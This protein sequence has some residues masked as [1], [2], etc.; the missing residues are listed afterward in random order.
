MVG[1]TDWRQATERS[2]RLLSRKKD[3]GWRFCMDYRMLNQQTVKDVFPLP[4][5]NVF[6]ETVG[7]AIML[8]KMDCW[9]G[10]HQI[11]IKRRGQTQDII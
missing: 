10:F 3:G 7:H 6:I 5:A 2:P 8:S 11:L 4:N 9:A 1:V